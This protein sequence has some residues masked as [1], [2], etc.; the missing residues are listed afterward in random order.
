MSKS[1]SNIS[2]SIKEIK[3]KEIVDKLEKDIINFNKR[4]NEV[5]YIK[6][7]YKN[8]KIK[9]NDI[10]KITLELYKKLSLLKNIKSI[11]NEFVIVTREINEKSKEIFHI[12]F[13]IILDIKEIN[14]IFY[15]DINDKYYLICKKI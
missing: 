5:N 2:K 14:L 12:K 7:E 11:L 3:I 6:K 15:K 10:N 4:D 13:T 1:S 9:I 8:I